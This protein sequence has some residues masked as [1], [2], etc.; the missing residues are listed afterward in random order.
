MAIV[1]DEYGSC[2]LVTIEDILEEIVG[3]IEDEHDE[4]ASLISE[5]DSGFVVNALTPI[6][7]FNLHFTTQL[8]S[9]E[10]ET[11][12]GLISHQFGHLPK[13]DEQITIDEFEFTVTHCD[14][15][16]IKFLQVC[17]LVSAA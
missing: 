3:E 14:E 8:H 7:D 2:G 6:D 9:D 11:I 15:R 12:G 1:L 10:Y 4:E 17:R 5:N 16:R 13:R